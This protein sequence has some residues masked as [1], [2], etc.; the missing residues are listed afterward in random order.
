MFLWQS[1]VCLNRSNPLAQFRKLRVLLCISVCI[2]Q[3]GKPSRPISVSFPT[4]YYFNP[5]V[6]LNIE[7]FPTPYGISSE[8][9]CTLTR[10]NPQR[11]GVIIRPPSLFRCKKC[12]LRSH[13]TYLVVIH[14]R[15]KCSIVCWHL[16]PLPARYVLRRRL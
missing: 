4:R 14:G 11:R 8:L 1:L 5:S 16:F 12:L 3:L 2:T 13:W 15:L 10:R 7:I 6:K 9:L